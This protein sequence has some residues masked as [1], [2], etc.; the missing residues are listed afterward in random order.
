MV[1]EYASKSLGIYT[2]NVLRMD[3]EYVSR[4][5]LRMGQHT[6]HFL[7]ILILIFSVITIFHAIAQDVELEALEGAIRVTAIQARGATAFL[8]LVLPVGTFVNAI[9]P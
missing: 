2:G 5:V 3:W 6:M 7:T 1:C 8:R 4:K 9:T